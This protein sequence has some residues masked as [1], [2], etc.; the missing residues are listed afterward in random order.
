MSNGVRDGHSMT[1]AGEGPL[2]HFRARRAVLQSLATSAGVAAFVAP[3]LAADH[4]HGA[5]AA[6]ANTADAVA[7]ASSLQYLDQH[8]FDTLALLSE[9]IVPGSRDAKVAEFLDRLLAVESL[10]T[11][12]YFTQVLGAFER[13]AREAQGKPW[14]M[15]TTEQSAVLLTKFSALPEG[16]VTRRGF[17]DLKRAI[18]ETYYSSEPGMK[19]LGWTGNFAFAPPQAGCS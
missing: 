12:K 9:Q 13:A 7:G 18:A 3:A 10:E 14:K 15:L 6:A 5:A 4:V 8:A 17:E 2:R 16:D 11:Q 1:D 19:E